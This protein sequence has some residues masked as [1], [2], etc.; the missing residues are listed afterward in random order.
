MRKATDHPAWATRY[1]D[2]GMELRLI[3]GKYYLYE[4]KTVYDKEKKRPKKIS[5]G[6]IGSITEQDGLIPSPKR[7]L[8]TAVLQSQ[9]VLGGI[10]CKEY[11]ISLLVTTHFSVYNTVLEKAFGE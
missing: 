8:K 3:N 9:T 11:G 10:L 1:R 5:G 4:Y 6:L 2:K 7:A